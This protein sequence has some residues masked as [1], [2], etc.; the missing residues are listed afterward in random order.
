MMADHRREL[1]ALR[2]ARLSDSRTWEE[3]ERRYLK[4]GEELERKLKA[5]RDELEAERIAHAATARALTALH[6]RT[7]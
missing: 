1:E 7:P 4:L 5:T 2:A 3:R 6:R